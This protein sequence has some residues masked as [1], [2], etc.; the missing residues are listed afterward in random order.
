MPAGKPAM[1]S[2]TEAGTGFMVPP[3][4]IGSVVSNSTAFTI[5]SSGASRTKYP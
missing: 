4:A 2:S 1:Y 5:C 3:V